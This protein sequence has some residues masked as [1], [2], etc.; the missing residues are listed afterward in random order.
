MRR[1]DWLGESFECVRARVHVSM[2]IQQ[3]RFTNP[4]V[5]LFNNSS[6]TGMLCKTDM[7]IG[8]I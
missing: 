3:P 8:E 2:N 6:L 7:H 1:H 5:L 4:R